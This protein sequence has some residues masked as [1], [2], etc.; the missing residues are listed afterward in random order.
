MGNIIRG[1]ECRRRWT[2]RNKF[3]SEYDDMERHVLRD[4]IQ[5]LMSQQHHSTSSAPR[6]SVAVSC[7]V[8][9]RSNRL[10][11]T[12]LAARKRHHVH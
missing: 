5:S 11:L 4:L 12:S 2:D 10:G 1:D 3:Q 6:T 7:D 8:D 9:V